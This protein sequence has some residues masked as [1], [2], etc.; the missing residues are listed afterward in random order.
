MTPY[1]DATAE[2]A[3]EPG[4]E[5]AARP[6]D[7]PGT[8]INPTIDAVFEQAGCE[9]ALCVRP[10]RLDDSDTPEVALRAHAPVVPA[11]T[12]KVLIALE[13]ETAFADGRLDP[14]EPVR[15]PAAARTPGPTG[16][17][18]FLDDAVVSWRDL[19]TL[20]LTISDN[21]ATDALIRGLGPAAVNS[22]AVRLGLTGTA[23]ESDTRTLL[24]SV[25]HD[26][27]RADW[28][29]LVAW[30]GDGARSPAELAEV[31]ELL[32]ATRALTPGAS[33]RSTPHDMAE[34]LRLLWSDRAGPAEACA[35]VRELMGH[36]LTRHR[37]A[38]GFPRQRVQVAAK[39]GGLLGVVR[40]EIGVI[41]FPDG[42][43]YAAT[44][45]TRSRPGSDDTAINAAI[46]TATARA[47]TL[48]RD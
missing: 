8:A 38:S 28:A 14:R 11:S 35:R 45:F 40:N 43:R 44:V 37:I 36:Q 21:D 18:L 16:A 34:L 20:A 29:D 3:D 47:V 5:P 13:A 23:L 42:H 4:T 6:T 33:T 10:L 22:T 39:S 41:T 25:G 17:S 1:V 19:V 30:S 12:I 26:L 46:G 48:L 27:G 31:D 2:P 7:E 32:P 15:L 24:D 9:G